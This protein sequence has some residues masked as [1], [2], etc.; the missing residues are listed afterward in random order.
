MR[1][2]TLAQGAGDQRTLLRGFLK[3]LIVTT[4]KRSYVRRR[5]LFEVL[6]WLNAE[7]QRARRKGGIGR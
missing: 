7:P 1:R 4:P 5:A 6:D 2:K 3:R